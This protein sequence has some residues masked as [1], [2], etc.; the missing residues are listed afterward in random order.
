MQPLIIEFLSQLPAVDV[1]SF[2]IIKAPS[3][4][5]MHA[6]LGKPSRIDSGE[7]PAPVGHRNNQIHIYDEL[8]ITFQEHHF[9]KLVL[10]VQCWFQT[11]DPEYRFTPQHDF[12]GRLIID[13]IQMPSGGNVQLFLANSPLI[14]SDGFGGTWR[15]NEGDFD[16]LVSS[17]GKLLPSKRRSKIKEITS[18]ALSWPHD[19]WQVPPKH[20]RVKA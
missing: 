2:R 6:V 15:Y 19:N 5:E 14:L 10:C 11:N 13:G 9:T 3:V 7:K 17:R 20:E 1:N 4:A 8:G 16:I 12:T 18:I